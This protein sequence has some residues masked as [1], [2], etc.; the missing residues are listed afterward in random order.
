MARL[1]GKVAMLIYGLP[2]LGK[3]GTL[4]NKNNKNLFFLNSSFTKVTGAQVASAN[5]CE[6]V[7]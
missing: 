7:N 6:P 5:L 3:H 2:H 1:P 4:Y